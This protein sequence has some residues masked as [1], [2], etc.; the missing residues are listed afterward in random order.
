[1]VAIVHV[2]SFPATSPTEAFL[3]F[4]MSTLALPAL[5]H[6]PTYP[7]DQGILAGLQFR[8]HAVLL[9]LGAVLA[10]LQLALQAG[11]LHLEAHNALEFA[12]QRIFRIVKLPGLLKAR[13]I[14]LH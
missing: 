7:G 6:D 4:G 13:F 3:F 10:H 1:M 11:N 8:R 12:L 9:P 14:G 5:A 2:L